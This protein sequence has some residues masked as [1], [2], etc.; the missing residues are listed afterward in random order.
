MKELE[1][2]REALIKALPARDA[3]AGA[4]L[5][6]SMAAGM[7]DGT[8]DYDIHAVFRDEALA[9]NPAL[10]DFSLELDRKCDLRVSSLSEFRALRRA[11]P[12]AREYL[13]VLYILD[14]ENILAAAVESLVHD[15]PGEAE[16]IVRARLD[17]YYDGF[18]RSL[19][20]F[21]HG[22]PF[23][24]HQ[25]AARS[26]DCLVET[27][28]ALSG[29]IPPFVDRAPLLLGTLD[30]LPCPEGELRAL[31]EK[32]A[33]SADVPAQI[34]LFGRVSAFMAETGRGEVLGAWKGVLEAE[35]ARHRIEVRR[36]PADG[37]EARALMGGLSDALRAITGSGGEAGFDPGDMADP[38]AAFAIAFQNGAPAGCGA[39]RPLDEKT[40]E[41][42][43]VYAREAGR[44][45]GRRVLAFLEGEAARLGFSAMVLET[46]RV[47]ERAVRFYLANGYRICENY[48][49]Y[50]GRAEAIC[51]RKDL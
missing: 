42:K 3:L 29:R 15:P 40:A 26:M 39:I 14:E 33:R 13:N 49:K 19:K 6:G 25:M 37:G 11:S 36:A 24:G 17:G 31:M 50:V 38:R 27:L 2:L 46:R 35:V 30:P 12:D 43:R 44:G 34:A 8:S 7:H 23:G 51:F 4:M 9:E 1:Y 32:I 21:R 28:W 41:L 10:R 48:G 18:F 22:F 45:V 5:L 20:C 47:N 16:E